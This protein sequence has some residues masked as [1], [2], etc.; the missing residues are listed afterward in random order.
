MENIVQSVHIVQTWKIRF[1]HKSP[2]FVLIYVGEKL[3]V[4]RTRVELGNV[5]IKHATR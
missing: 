1:G 5:A 3:V 2:N 4:Q